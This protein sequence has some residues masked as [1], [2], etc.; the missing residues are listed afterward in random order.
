MYFSRRRKYKPGSIYVNKKLKENKL[1][2]STYIPLQP[3]N[4]LFYL[5][6]LSA[7]GNFTEEFVVESKMK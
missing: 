5:Y 3:I 2:H 6:K 1:R 4:F 7:C